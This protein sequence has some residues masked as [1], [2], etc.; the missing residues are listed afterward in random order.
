MKLDELYPDASPLWM[1]GD[2]DANDR[3]CVL[4]CHESH[5]C[6]QCGEATTWVEVNFEAHL[7]SEECLDK[8]WAEYARALSK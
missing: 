8:A 6:W 1:P 3:G 7:C 5:P 2:S 4:K